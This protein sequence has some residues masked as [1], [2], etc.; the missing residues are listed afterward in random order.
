MPRESSAPSR[1]TARLVFPATADRPPALPSRIPSAWPWIALETFTSRKS[2]TTVFARWIRRES[3]RQ[4]RGTGT[5]GFSGDGGP[6]TQA[7][8]N[9]PAGLAL[10]ATGNIYVADNLNHRIRRV[11]APPPPAPVITQVVNGASFL[12]PIVPNSW[13]T[14][15]GSNLA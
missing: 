6:A 15:K 12:T 11:S 14:I 7:R 5:A 8:L 1:A 4:W 3:Y 2:T 10:D 9:A 13:A